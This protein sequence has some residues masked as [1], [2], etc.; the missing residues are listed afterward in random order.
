MMTNKKAQN[1]VKYAFKPI[2]ITG[3]VICFDMDG[4]LAEWGTDGPEPTKMPEYFTN[5]PKD[6]R[7]IELL[8][9]LDKDGYTIVILSSVYDFGTAARDK[10]KWLFDDSVGLGHIR[11]VFVPYGK[12]EK[13]E[14]VQCTGKKILV[15]DYSVNLHEWEKDGGIGI[16]F[17]NGFNG[18]NGTWKKRIISEDM[19]LE[20]MKKVVQDAIA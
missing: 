13:R 18:N 10:I 8:K 19:N 5:R 2:N 14:F 4:V 9:E 17:M 11:R 3:D 12:A 7:G 1:L 6:M 16:K 15:D 20:Q